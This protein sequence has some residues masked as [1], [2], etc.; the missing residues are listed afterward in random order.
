M[1]SL[2]TLS[3]TPK[4]QIIWTVDNKTSP[5]AQLIKGSTVTTPEIKLLSTEP[6][7][8]EDAKKITKHLQTWL[9]GH[10]QTILE[11][12]F[13]LENLEITGAAKGISFQL[14]EKFGFLYRKDVL[15]LIKELSKEDRQFLSKRGVR[16]GAYYV[17]QRDMLKPAAVNL[18][19][20]LWLSHHGA[21]ELAITPPAGNVSMAV[22]KRAPKDFYR[23]IGFPIF[24]TTAVRMDMVERVNSA[25]FDGA[26][27]GKYTFD[28]A[29]A[30]TIGVGV[31]ALYLVL[32]DLGFK[33]ETI[34]EEITTKDVKEAPEQ[35]ETRV[36]HLKK[37]PIKPHRQK[38]RTNQNKAAPESEKE[39]DPNSPFA[40]LQGLIKK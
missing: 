8:A 36:Y 39:P 32:A 13:S 9:N 6:I 15:G 14:F 38:R 11:P 2:D 33:Y 31:D 17:Y 40:A 24:G 3:I 23:T 37:A 25:V 29:L 1:T 27:D 20:A 28:P 12:L 26:K 5:I 7:M 22:D 18:R 21:N 35:K 30:S 19:A 10:I 34:T 4:G 16:L